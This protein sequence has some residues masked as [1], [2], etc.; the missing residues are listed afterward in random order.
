MNV[1]NAQVAMFEHTVITPEAPKDVTTVVQP[2]RYAGVE[3]RERDS[4]RWSGGVPRSVLPKIP[5]ALTAASGAVRR[6]GRAAQSGRGRHAE[7]T[8]AM[9]PLV[10]RRR[11]STFTCSEDK[12]C[13]HRSDA[14]WQHRSG[15]A[16]CVG[17]AS[18]PQPLSRG[19]FAP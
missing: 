1:Q 12:S 16:A 7:A 3:A 13:I 4:R 2:P 10:E 5:P 8:F 17:G 18:V 11:A 14:W 9:R 15:M 6:R 19:V